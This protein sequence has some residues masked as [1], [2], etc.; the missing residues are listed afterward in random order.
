MGNKA[1]KD[2]FIFPGETTIDILIHLFVLL[3]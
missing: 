1:I 2:R 3:D